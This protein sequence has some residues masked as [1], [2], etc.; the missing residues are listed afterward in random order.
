MQPH[1]RYES[2]KSQNWPQEPPTRDSRSFHR[3]NLSV[4]SEATNA[5]EHPDQNG[6]WEYMGRERH[7]LREGNPGHGRG[8][9]TAIDNQ[10]RQTKQ[11]PG[12]DEN[13]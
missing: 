7:D 2:S 11:I 1:G 5:Y 13:G 10:V 3:E 9:E 6:E 8:S 4:S 12:E